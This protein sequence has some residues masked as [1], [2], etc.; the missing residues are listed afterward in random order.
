[1]SRPLRALVRK[2]WRVLFGSPIAYLVLTMTALVT[3]LVFFEHLR[4]YNQILFVFASTTMGGFETDTIPDHINLR[5]T[6]FFP[7]MEQL[8]LL[9]IV[10]IPLVTMRVFAEERARGTDELLATTRLTATET[11][12]G[13]FCVTFAF[14]ALMMAVSFVYPLTAIVQGGLGFQ[15]LVAVFVGL[16]LLAT[17]IASIGLACSAFTR[18]QIIAAAGTVA[19][20]FLFYDFGWTHAF[21]SEPVAR[22]LEVI[23]LHPHFGRFSEGL[24]YLDDIAYFAALAVIAG[25]VSRLSLDLRR[26]TG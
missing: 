19:L 8:G 18:S 12:L 24:I 4:L 14:V 9:L 15:H 13:K 1:M 26:V 17:G 22:F 10:P 20:A 23:S 5:D 16:L 2:E 21:V 7:V 11:V 6:V 25:A 3:A